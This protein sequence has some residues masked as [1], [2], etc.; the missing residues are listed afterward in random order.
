MVADKTLK[1]MSPAGVASKFSTGLP[2]I[3]TAFGLTSTAAQVPVGDVDGVC[4]ARALKADYDK[5]YRDGFAAT[6][7]ASVADKFAMEKLNLKYSVSPIN[8][9]RVTAYAPERYYGPSGLL[10]G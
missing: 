3:G 10:R 2:F 7:D 5:N 6:G 4:N 9:N 8:G 1:S